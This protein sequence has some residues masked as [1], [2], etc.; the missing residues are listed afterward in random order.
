MMTDS[1]NSHGA[2]DF[3]S[4]DIHS[5]YLGNCENRLQ[6][7]C[8]V[9]F[10]PHILEEPSANLSMTSGELLDVKIIL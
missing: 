3:H 4:V 8:S 10:L 5:Y 1:Q 7:R 6:F 2:L 9:R